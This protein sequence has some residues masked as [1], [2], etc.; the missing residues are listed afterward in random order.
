MKMIVMIMMI[1]IDNDC[2][3]KHNQGGCW[4]K[5]AIKMAIARINNETFLDPDLL[6]SVS[7]S[8][9]ESDPKAAVFFTTGAELALSG[10]SATALHSFLSPDGSDRVTLPTKSESAI[11][12]TKDSTPARS[13]EDVLSPVRVQA[14]ELA[15]RYGGLVHNK[16]WYY[17]A[18]KTT[19]RAFFMAFVNAKGS[20]SLRMFD[21]RTGL[22]LPKQY[23]PGNY[24]DQFRELIEG[25]TELTV[26]AQPNLERD[27]KERLPQSTFELL[28]SQIA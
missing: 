27:C 25:A 28:R 5:G 1:F 18:D 17:R 13:L 26:R 3:Q 6:L 22:A 11:D 12:R 7:F 9:L 23:K 10:D 20:C 21:A 8:D 2:A 4:S 24:Q 15:G 14:A 19:S 16:G